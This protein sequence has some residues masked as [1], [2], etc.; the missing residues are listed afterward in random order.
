MKHRQ[1][2]AKRKKPRNLLFTMLQK[3]KLLTAP[4]SDYVKEMKR[5][6]RQNCTS[7]LFKCQKSSSDRYY[8]SVLVAQN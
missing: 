3:N 1:F 7:S 4:L 8:F 6:T 2:D 5:P